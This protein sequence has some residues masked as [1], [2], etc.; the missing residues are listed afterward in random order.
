MF[1]VLEVMYPFVGYIEADV[2]IP[3][4]PL[5]FPVL[6]RKL[7]YGDSDSEIL[8]IIGINV[9]KSCKEMVSEL[10]CRSGIPEVWNLAV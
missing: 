8:V 10:N 6:V 9:I 4:N 1:I 7:S 3:E 2:R 5:F